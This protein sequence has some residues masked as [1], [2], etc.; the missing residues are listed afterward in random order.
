MP[1]KYIL[2]WIDA[3]EQKHEDKFIT[4]YDRSRFIAKQQISNNFIGGDLLV[5]SGGHITL[6]YHIGDYL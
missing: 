3:N 2:K 1:H 6:Q 5:S 4:S